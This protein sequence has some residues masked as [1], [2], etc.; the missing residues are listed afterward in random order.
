[1][2]DRNKIRVRRIKRLV[3][4]FF[5]CIFVTFAATPAFAEEPPAKPSGIKACVV[6]NIEN[7]VT[8]YESW[9]NVKVAP[10]P[11]AKLM[12]A[13]LAVE[14]LGAR[15]DDT[16]LVSA[17]MVSNVAGNTIGLKMGEH[18]KLRDMLYAMILCGANDAAQVIAITATG[19]FEAFVAKMNARAAE[20]GASSTRYETL[21]GL[22]LGEA[23][24]T[25]TD[26]LLI[27]R[28]AYSLPDLAEIFACN[29]Y[30]MGATDRSEART[31]Q[32]K[33]RFVTPGDSYCYDGAMGLSYGSTTPSGYCMAVVVKRAAVSYRCIVLGGEAAT[34]L[35]RAGK[36]LLNYAFS[37]YRYKT[38]LSP[39]DVVGEVTVKNA[40][41]SHVTTRPT[42]SVSVYARAEEEVASRVR[43]EVV[44]ADREYYA[45]LPAGTP[46]GHADVYFDGEWIAR[47][48]LVTGYDVAQSNWLYFWHTVSE[49][50]LAESTLIL[51]GLACGVGGLILALSLRRRRESRI[52]RDD[53]DLD[54]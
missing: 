28:Y 35:Y 45:P 1:M 34:D 31:L 44:L 11:T 47:V 14:L 2:K 36:T 54:V 4:L 42:S 51:L 5:A 24:T 40:K 50:L 22:D 37:A 23:K 26:T 27:A 17:A 10:G 33:N 29:A 25:V 43:T 6:Y 20:L 49:V 8:V 19:S 46:V 13:I 12:T 32:T 7:D 53:A 18:V 21:T 3:C 41:S 9:A 39:L 52:A 38:I 48:E 15:L 30:T 16:V